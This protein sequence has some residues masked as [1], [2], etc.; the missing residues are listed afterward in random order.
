MNRIVDA[1]PLESDR[2]RRFNELVDRYLESK[3]AD[4]ESEKRIESQ[5]VDWQNDANSLEPL[6][7]RSGLVKE[8]QLTAKALGQ[9]AGSGLNALT[10]IKLNATYSEEQRK[11]ASEALKFLN[12]QAANAQLILAIMPGI[13]KLV[14]AAT[15]PG[16]CHVVPGRW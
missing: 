11:P 4:K 3:C 5:L 16:T 6:T 9:T 8:V 13:Q 14:D 7:M 10:F 15:A 2:A 12:A 1:V